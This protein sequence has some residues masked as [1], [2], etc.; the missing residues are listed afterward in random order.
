MT[1]EERIAAKN[2]L[3]VMGAQIAEIDA[4]LA[5]LVDLLV[6]DAIL[7]TMAAVQEIN[8]KRRREALQRQYNA[9]HASIPHF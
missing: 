5:R 7:P 3:G 9:V 4:Q 1:S 6:A 8:L 2:A